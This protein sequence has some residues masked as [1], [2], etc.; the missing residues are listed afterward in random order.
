[1]SRFE[2]F[3]SLKTT[4]S[5]IRASGYGQYY[6][7]KTTSGGKVYKVHC[8]DSRL[9]DDYTDGKRVQSR[10]REVFNFHANKY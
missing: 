8:T 4:Y 7:I 9:Y 3:K 5:I 1:M 10:L 6:I 2:L